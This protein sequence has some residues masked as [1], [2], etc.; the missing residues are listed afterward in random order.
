M[1]NVKGASTDFFLTTDL[2]KQCQCVRPLYN[3]MQSGDAIPVKTANLIKFEGGELGHPPC[4]LL[5]YS[6]ALEIRDPGV[7]APNI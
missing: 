2:Y 6:L 5:E 1:C 3:A 7:V 4:D